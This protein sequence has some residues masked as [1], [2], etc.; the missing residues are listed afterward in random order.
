MKKGLIVTAVL[1]V[2][3]FTSVGM[4]GDVR[5]AGSALI[6]F[7]LYMLPVI[8][9]FGFLN[10]LIKFLRWHLYLQKAGV[11][12]SIKKSL[13]IFVAGLSMS[14]TPGKFGFI[15][16]S[17]MLKSVSGHPLIATSPVIIAELYMDLIV[18][19][20]IS[21]F[22]LRL[23]G[24]DLW[25][26]MVICILPLLGLFPGV[27]ELAAGLVGKIPLFSGK[28]A[29]MKTALDTI[30]ALFGPR[31][32]VLSFL[33]TLTAWASEGVALHLI[34]KC[35]GFSMGVFDAT[36]VFG[37]ATL[38]GALSMLPGGLVVTD[39]SLMGLIM[40]AGIPKTPAALA[41]IMGR[42]FTLWLAVLIGSTVLFINRK[43]LYGRSDAA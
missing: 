20:L 34:L 24:T 35:L 5:S 16:K 6:K 30:F 33:I 12:V 2:I 40:N 18:L 39:A 10:D 29:E 21:L 14:A 26:V 19:S 38:L 4:W 8:A 7:P 43:Y 36:A 17:Q 22:S 41:A 31:V 15:I 1:M 3:A 13:T 42:I 27:P 32:L 9:L 23:L 28:A 11:A 37:F 25:M